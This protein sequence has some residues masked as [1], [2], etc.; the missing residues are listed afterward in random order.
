MK[1]EHS[2]VWYA[3]FAVGLHD[4]VLIAGGGNAEV[5][6]DRRPRAARIHAASPKQAATLERETDRLRGFASGA[7]NDDERTSN[8]MAVPIETQARLLAR[9]G[10]AVGGHTPRRPLEAR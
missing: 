5:D 7:E 2:T 3:S 1:C 4:D 6:L 10:P 8:R 9:R